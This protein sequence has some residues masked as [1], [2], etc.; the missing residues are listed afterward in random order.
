MWNKCV[1]WFTII[2]LCDT[3]ICIDDC[4][5]DMNSDDNRLLRFTC[6]LGKHSTFNPWGGKRSSNAE[7][8]ESSSYQR[9]SSSWGEKRSNGF[10]FKSN[11]KHRTA[12][13]YKMEIMSCIRRFIND[14]FFLDR[15]LDVVQNECT[16]T[17]CAN[18]QT[19][20]ARREFTAWENCKLKNWYR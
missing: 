19:G 20:M 8:L 7:T 11:Y 1:G 14:Q 16:T 2:I 6:L 18:D 15:C 5:P 9:D 10:S 12:R 3:V 13:T 4:P 17:Y